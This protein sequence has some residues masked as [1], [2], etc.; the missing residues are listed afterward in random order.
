MPEI[1]ILDCTLR[2]GGYINDWDFSNE[3]SLKI[4]NALLSSNIDFLEL[5]FLTDE[6]IY[7]NKTLFNN[8]SDLKNIIPPSVNKDKLFLM[9]T[10]GKY[11]ISKIGDV[12]KS[13]CAGIRLIYKKHQSNDAL[14]YAKILK[15]K[16]YKL[17][18]NPTFVSGYNYDEFL[19]E[20]ELINKISP[21]AAG[22]V[23]SMGVLNEEETLNLFNLA[24][25]NL[26]TDISVSYHT[27]NNLNLS[28][29]N[30]KKLIM[31]SSL[32]KIIVD[33]TLY[34]MGRGAGNLQTETLIKFLNDNYAANYNTELIAD[35]I[36]DEIIPIYNKTPWGY[37]QIYNITAQ[38]RCHPNYAK[39]LTDKNIK[40]P[41]LIE[42]I[43]KNIPPDKKTVF[44]L[45]LIKMLI[46]NVD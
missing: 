29:E 11:D 28:F 18:I 34:A 44:D 12:D 9:L 24:D 32:R 26:S 37:S 2:E 39:F 1:K 42:K 8:L 30:T 14:N 31:S 13:P 36:N 45:N 6:K 10:Y 43:L 19:R 15:D 46:S 17:F 21:F 22:I 41:I 23:D 20:I 25:E 35:I 5:G 3:K 16:G 7:S 33:T 4:I 38:N 27:H 40:S